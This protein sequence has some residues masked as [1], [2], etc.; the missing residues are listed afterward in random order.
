MTKLHGW[1]PPYPDVSHLISSRD[2]AEKATNDAMEHL[3]A[4][5][6]TETEMNQLAE[7]TARVC[8]AVA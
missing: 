8:A 5:H 2:A 7:Q 1:A 4:L 6:L 3:I